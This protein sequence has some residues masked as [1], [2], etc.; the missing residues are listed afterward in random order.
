MQFVI[1]LSI[2]KK[3]QYIALNIAGVAQS[4]EQLI[5]NYLLNHL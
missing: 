4:V 3:E 2:D 1:L 5:R